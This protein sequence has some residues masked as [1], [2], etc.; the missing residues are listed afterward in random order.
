MKPIEFSKEER[1]AITAKLRDYFAR[2][3]DQELGQLPAEMLLDFIGK[4]IGGAFYNRGVH[5]AQR[6]VQQK[7]EDIV[8]ALYGLERAAPTR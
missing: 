1:A 6:L 7:A 8:E 4:E 3:L 2:E 5:D